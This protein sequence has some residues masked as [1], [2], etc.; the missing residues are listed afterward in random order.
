MSGST[1]PGISTSALSARIVETSKAVDTPPPKIAI[2]AVKTSLKPGESVTVTFTLSAISIDFSAA[3]IAVSGG[4]LLNFRGSGSSYTADFT[5]NGAGPGRVSVGSSMFSDAAGNFNRDGADADNKVAFQMNR[6]PTGSVEII[7]KAQP[8][9]V[10]TVRDTVKDADGIPGSGEGA[11]RYQWFA[12][13]S[14]LLV[15]YALMYRPRP[16]E[17]YPFVMVPYIGKSYAVGFQDLGKSLSVVAQYTDLKGAR[18][19]VKSASTGA[20]KLFTASAGADLLIGA[21]GADVMDGLGGNDTIFGRAGDDSL[22]GAA[23]NDSLMGEE[24]NDTLVGGSGADTLTGG[25]GRDTFVFA[26]GSSGQTRNLD[27]IADYTKGAV[28]T[29]DLIDFSSALTVGGSSAAASSTQASINPSTGEAS[30][31][32]GSGTTLADAL[33]D[34]AARFTASTDAAGEFA[35]FRVNNTGN[36]YVFISDG[37]KGVAANDVVIQLT[38]ITSVAAID[39]TGGNLTLIA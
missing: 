34:I 6:A 8:G 17:V 9:S 18:E 14:P 24:G 13:G 7:G 12:D 23:G 3:D 21:G 22:L 10:L 2:A 31:A 29:G 16:G 33:S 11:I 39:L 38:G 36:F 37:N 5:L 19:E 1:S 32:T 30:F 20:I 26:P 15:D 27:V 35:L 25:T 4:T 28:G